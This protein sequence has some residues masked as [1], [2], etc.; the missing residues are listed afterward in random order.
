MSWISIRKTSLVPPPGYRIVRER[1]RQILVREGVE[2]YLRQKH[3][4]DAEDLWENRS[5]SDRNMG[6]G[7]VLLVGH[8]VA[9]AV[10]KYHHGGLFRRITRDIFVFGS[11]P[12]EEVVVTEAAQSACIPTVEILAAIMQ[13][14]WGICYRAYLLT[15]YLPKAVN[16]VEYLGSKAP[17]EERHE[18]IKLA[19]QAVR[20]MHQSGIYHADLQLR[21]F[22]VTRGEEVQVYVIDFDRSELHTW[23][24]PSARI[25]NLK[26][27]DRS[28]EKLKADGAFFSDKDKRLF[29]RSYLIQDRKMR[30]LVLSYLKWY[31]WHH[32]MYTLGWRI[33][34]LLYPRQRSSRNSATR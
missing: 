12:F 17:D 6:R 26:R 24:S 19:A 13:R 8:P 30:P 11:R 31:K 2:D 4:L 3:L 33:A 10:R 16:L 34:R 9:V 1:T 18:V 29:C 27:L 25:K 7:E 20:T 14:K 22:L 32:F 5:S 28:A 21:N 23:L 15:R